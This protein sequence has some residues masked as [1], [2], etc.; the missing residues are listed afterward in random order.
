MNERTSEERNKRVGIYRIYRIY[1]LY[2]KVI[3][4][5]VISINI[6]LTSD[7]VPRM[8]YMYVYINVHMSTHPFISKFSFPYIYL[9]IYFSWQ[10]ERG[11]VSRVESSRDNR[12]RIRKANSRQH[13]SREKNNYLKFE[14][15]KICIYPYPHESPNIPI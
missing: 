13:T 14:N 11:C 9:F 10:K 4:I 3:N 2:N 6:K 12:Q 1:R 7:Q 5:K 8:I 15:N